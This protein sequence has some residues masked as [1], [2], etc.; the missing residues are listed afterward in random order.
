MS[1]DWC[2][3]LDVFYITT[4]IYY[5]N[6]PPH[7]GHAY[8]TVF[9]DVLARYKK[10]L[11]Y[12]TFFLTGN[13]EHGLKIQNVAEKQGK[14]PKE[15]VDEMAE[16]FKS[17][18]RSLDV[19]YDH[20]IR[21]TD[22]YHEKAVKEAFN[23]IY[24]K[25]LIYK[26]KYSG[27]YCVDCEKYY[28]PG[29]YIEVDGKPYCPLHNKPLE[30]MEEETYYFK[31]SEF[32]DYL[33]DVL[34]NKDIVYPRSYAEEVIAKIEKEGLRDLSIA[35][36]VERVWWGIPV[37]FDEKYVIYVWFDALLNYISAIGYSVDNERFKSYWSNVHHVIG[38]DILWFHT[39]VWFSILKALDIEP[40]RKLLV[41]SY[42]TVKGAKMSKS[43]GNIVSIEELLERYGS[44][45]A[46]RYVLMR[47]F[48]MDKDSEFNYELIDSIYNSELAD[49]YG[50]LVRRV[51]VLALKKLHGKVY[52]RSLDSKLKEELNEKLN[53]YIE[54]MESFDVARGASIAMDVARIGNQYL[55][56][57]KPWEKSDPSRELYTTIEIIKLATTMLAPFTPRTAK[58]I[59]SVFGFTIDNPRKYSFEAVERFNVTDAPILYKK[60]TPKK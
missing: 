7:I 52:R 8:T 47:I 26:A 56:E 43:V 35:R 1:I 33:L 41:H 4:P 18:W 57:T 46:V 60:I 36:P 10:L 58:T 32:K 53:A 13:D 42:L 59:S 51:G 37:P 48:N 31:L 44:P 9:A 27:W 19:E 54:A 39:A 17:Y 38:K 6:A 15:F 25:G 40:P 22:D 12:K 30:F 20:F 28:T 5:P 21:T 34:R 55:N 29:E 49:T 11:G 23:Y 2:I 3:A 14:K 45:D 50:N 16:V 24:K